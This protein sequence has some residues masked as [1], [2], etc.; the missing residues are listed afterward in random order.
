MLDSGDWLIKMTD[1]IISPGATRIHGITMAMSLAEGK[2]IADALA[3]FRGSLEQADVLVAHNMKFD[4]NV[5]GAEFY[6]DIRENPLA[7]V[8]HYCT[9][10][11]AT[12]Y[13]ALPGK[14]SNKWPTLAEL[15]H[16]LFSR[17]FDGAHNA[18]VDVSVTRQCYF[19]LLARGV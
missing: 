17:P 18:A 19:A 3:A 9:M 1:T 7:D 8:A 13:C 12:D 16:K 2:P 10:E 11:A 4:F 5:L 6:R 14:Y 15:H